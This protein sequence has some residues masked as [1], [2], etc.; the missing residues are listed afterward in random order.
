VD[1]SRRDLPLGLPAAAGIGVY[2][3]RQRRV[4][5]KAFHSR[6][7]G[8]E[9]SRI[10]SAAYNASNNFKSERIDTQAVELSG[11]FSVATTLNCHGRRR[12]REHSLGTTRSD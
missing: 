2:N 3:N 5:G 4:G 10:A 12:N 9:R 1:P 6:L 8:S 11:E 7:R